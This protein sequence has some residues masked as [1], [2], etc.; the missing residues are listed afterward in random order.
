MVCKRVMDIENVFVPRIPTGIPELD[1]LYDGD[2]VKNGLGLPNWGLPDGKISLWSGVKGIGKS[3]A[4]I[5]IARCATSLQWRKV[6]YFQGE[7]DLSS[8]R[9]WVGEDG[10]PISCLFSVSD[11]FDLDEQISDIKKTLPNIV[12]VDSINRIEEFG[13]GV[14]SNIKKIHDAYMDAI[15]YVQSKGDMIHIIFLCQINQDGSVKGST[16]LGHLVDTEASFI[17]W[18]DPAMIGPM[19][20]HFLLKLGDK[21]RYGRTGDRFVI[22]WEHL[23]KKASCVSSERKKDTKWVKVHESIQKKSIKKRS[24]LNKFFNI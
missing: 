21:H 13:S 9:H 14:K 8:F 4:T 22:Y 6:L 24:L 16:D 10:N 12:I 23:E 7:T 18:T 20:G 17:P 2:S 19:P 15:R 1:W 11:S 5:E 3:R